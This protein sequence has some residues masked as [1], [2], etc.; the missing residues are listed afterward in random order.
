LGKA[1]V[2]EGCGQHQF[3]SGAGAPRAAGHA[4]TVGV[5]AGDGAE[6]DAADAGDGPAQT[7]VGDVGHRQVSGH[8]QPHD[9]IALTGGPL[10]EHERL[11]EVG[12]PRRVVLGDRSAREGYAAPV[13]L[14]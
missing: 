7:A 1:S 6:R 10:G 2:D 12:R 14:A 8:G 11:L 4:P 13:V 9:Q 3:D 5:D